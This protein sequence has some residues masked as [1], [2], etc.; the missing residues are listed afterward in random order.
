MIMKLLRSVIVF[1]FLPFMSFGWNAGGHYIAGAIAFYYLETY[2]PGTIPKIHNILKFHPWINN[3]IWT[4]HLKGLGGEQYDAMLFMLASNFPEDAKDSSY[5]TF[6]MTLWHRVDYPFIPEGSSIQGANPI[7]PNSEQVLTEL[8][9][10]IGAEPNGPQK[11]IDVCW[12]M[13]LI[14][15]VH[16]PMNCITMFDSRHPKGDDGGRST[17]ISYAS[18]TID[19][20]GFWNNIFV[21]DV[22]SAPAKALVLMANNNYSDQSLPELYKV[23]NVSQWVKELS[24]EIAR[25]KAYRDGDIIGTNELPSNLPDGYVDDARTI[26]EKLMVL[27]GKRIGSKLANAL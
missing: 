12:I 16:Q 18:T 9:Q 27:A 24:F 17:Y 14:A 11:A 19:L 10:K 26:T 20:Y 1:L 3:P 5:G 25:L 6:P 21:S 7:T 8:L 4:N 23:T 13:H 22:T 2:R 15:D